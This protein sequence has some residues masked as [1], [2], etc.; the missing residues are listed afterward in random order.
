MSTSS[1]PFLERFNTILHDLVTWPQRCFVSPKSVSTAVL[2]EVDDVASLGNRGCPLVE[3]EVREP[4]DFQVR[5]YEVE[6]PDTRA[7]DLTEHE[8]FGLA[9]D[10][11]HHTEHLQ[12]GEVV[13]HHCGCR[14]IVSVIVGDPCAFGIKPPLVDHPAGRELVGGDPSDIKVSL[15][16]PVQVASELRELRFLAFPTPPELLRRVAVVSIIH[17]FGHSDRG[18]V[19]EPTREGRPHAVEDDPLSKQR[20]HHPLRIR[21]DRGQEA[22]RLAFVADVLRQEMV[23]DIGKSWIVSPHPDVGERG[24]GRLDLVPVVAKGSE[25]PFAVLQMEGPQTQFVFDAHG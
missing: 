20:A 4:S 18:I 19:A 6:N 23:I 15:T 2:H 9:V 16:D 11:E 22:V 8:P 7:V 10:V 25:H 5:F 24:F 21:T 13:E 1:K 14:G 12:L 17:Q 3:S